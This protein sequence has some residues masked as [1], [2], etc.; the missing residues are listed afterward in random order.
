MDTP[1]RALGVDATT[2]RPLEPVPAA[3]ARRRAERLLRR[4]RPPRYG[5]AG[6]DLASAGWGVVFAEGVDADA[7]ARDALGPLLE[8][9]RRQ[10]GDR[11]REL[12]YRP[13]EGAAAFRS[14]LRAGHGRVDPRQVPWYL[15]LVG[16]PEELP[17]GFELDLDVPHAV[18]RLAADDADDLAAYARRVIEAEDRPPHRAPRAAVFAPTHPDDP[19]TAACA[20]HLARPL[21][22]IAGPDAGVLIG[23][24]ATRAALLELIAGGPDLLVVA[25]H[26]ASYPRNHRCQRE[27]QGALIC[28][29]WPGS[30]RWPRAI[31]PAHTVAAED[32]P[33][34][35]LDGGVA[36][37][38]G[39]HTA[40]TPRREFYDGHRRKDARALTSRP[41]VAALPR[42]LLGREGGALA[43]VGHVGRAFEASFFWRGARQSGPFEDAVRALLDGRRLGEALDGFGQRFADVAVTWARSRMDPEA[44]EPDP[45][46]LWVAFHDARSWSLLGNPAVRLPACA[47][48]AE[49]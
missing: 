10:A 13:G 3:V 44:E 33:T 41:F 26:S 27:R 15:L 9:R 25:G 21:A 49:R 46:G 24:G 17:H 47:E 34:G 22:D 38:F 40:G 31:P 23:D 43:V 8:R 28:A 11:Y 16:D 19:A 32:L 45:L 14:R 5:V 48:L 39:C 18:G 35:A 1:L 36:V 20:E 37:L 30:E 29:D 7:D 6:G 12:T 42:R 2:G 4:A